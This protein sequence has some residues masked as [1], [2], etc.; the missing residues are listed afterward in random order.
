MDNLRTKIKVGLPKAR[1]QSIFPDSKSM[2]LTTFFVDGKIAPV[3]DEP[4]DET[5]KLMQWLQREIPS[6]FKVVQTSATGLYESF[7]D[8]ESGC[9]QIVENGD[10]SSVSIVT[11][12]TDEERHFDLVDRVK[13]ELEKANVPIM[14]SECEI[15]IIRRC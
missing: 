6:R 11:H 15:T 8:M 7:I 2:T 10:G 4:Y 3:N 14:D 5:V 1:M 12:G 9:Y 13:E